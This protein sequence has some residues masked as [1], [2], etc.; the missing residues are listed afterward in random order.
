ME[1]PD[2]PVHAEPL[3]FRHRQMDYMDYSHA[4]LAAEHVGRYAFAAPLC[5]GKRVL[6]VARG[7]GYGAFI[8]A[9]HGAAEVVSVDIAEEGISVGQKRFARDGVEF[10]VGDALDLSR[11]LGNRTPFDIVIS[12]ETIGHVSDPRR[13]LDGLRR[14][15][16]PGGVIVLSCPND[17]PES[18]RGDTSQLNLRTYTLADFQQLTTDVLGPA[19]RWYLGTPLQGVVIAEPSSSLLHRDPS[20]LAVSLET[21]PGHVLGTQS[22][23]RAM[24]ESCAFYVGIWGSSGNAVHVVV[25]TS[26]HAC[27]EPWWA[28]KLFKERVAFLEEQIGELRRASMVEKT[29][30]SIQS[31]KERVASLVASLEG[32]IAESVLAKTQLEEA[33]Q[34]IAHLRQIES[35]RGYWLLQRYYVLAGAPITGPVIQLVRRVARSVLHLIRRLRAAS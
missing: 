26:R 15:L 8:L 33:Y 4:V 27:L 30:L 32:Q 13:F 16:T 9:R 21:S 5:A 18:T 34:T 28:L 11:I 31:L 7:E 29:R 25:P 24:P 17:A 20:L 12:F 22:N 10:L 23:L 14:M 19:A 6:I 3:H 2:R 35:S 1:Q